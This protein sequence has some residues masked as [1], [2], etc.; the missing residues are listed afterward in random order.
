MKTKL[1]L[2]EKYYGKKE[3]AKVLGIGDRQYARI[4][5]SGKST[6]TIRILVDELVA[7]IKFFQLTS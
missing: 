2:L 1:N 3:V 6:E 4:K 7:K 5:K